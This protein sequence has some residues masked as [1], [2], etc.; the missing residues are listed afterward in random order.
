MA[1]RPAGLE[2]LTNTCH[3]NTILQ[4]FY[5][6][7]AIREH[8]LSVELKSV[9]QEE[10]EILVLRANDADLN[11][12][13]AFVGSEFLIELKK[14]FSSLQDAG[15]AAVRPR[16]RLANAAFLRPDSGLEEPR[17]E[18]DKPKIDSDQMVTSSV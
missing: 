8:V 5:S 9:T 11:L 12:G 17:V 15:S 1:P 10:L 3:L 14:L 18:L 16:Q 13:R 6:V 2:N 7:R 4:Y